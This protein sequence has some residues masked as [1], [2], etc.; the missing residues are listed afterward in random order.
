LLLAGNKEAESLRILREG[1]KDIPG[2]IEVYGREYVD[3]S[4]FIGKRMLALIEEYR[5]EK[6]GRGE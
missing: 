4:D 1:I 2:R 3:D 6:A 5:Q